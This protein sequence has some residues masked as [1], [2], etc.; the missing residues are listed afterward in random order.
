M[1]NNAKPSRFS[2]SGSAR[3]Q[4]SGC[5]PSSAQAKDFPVRPGAAMPLVKGCEK[6]DH[7][8]LFVLGSG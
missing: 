3:Y 5:S 6:Q 4:G 2:L 8:V 1:A 7:A